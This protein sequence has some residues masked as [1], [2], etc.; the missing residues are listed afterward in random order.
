MAEVCSTS[1]LVKMYECRIF[2]TTSRSRRLNN[3]Q[4]EYFVQVFGEKK[5]LLEIHERADSSWNIIDLKKS[6]K[7]KVST[8][9]LILTLCDLELI[10]FVRVSENLGEILVRFERVP[11]ERFLTVRNL[12][13]F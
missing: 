13:V 1:Y 11:R 9:R 6:R 2:C 7:F 4:M 8:P 5:I 12:V 10:F 3:V